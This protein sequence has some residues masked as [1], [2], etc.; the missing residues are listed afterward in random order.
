MTI[1]SAIIYWK[2]VRFFDFLKIV[3]FN[4]SQNILAIK[5]QYRKF[6]IRLIFCIAIVFYK[7]SSPLLFS[8]VCSSLLTIWV[9]VLSNGWMYT[10][11]L[12]FLVECLPF[13]ECKLTLRNTHLQN[14]LSTCRTIKDKTKR[15]GD[16]LSEFNSQIFFGVPAHSRDRNWKGVSNIEKRRNFWTISRLAVMNTHARNVWPCMHQ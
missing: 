6:I 3:V 2:E 12:Y 16:L 7:S 13:F 15:T 1:N 8:D 14:F 11:M 5:C 9:I 10:Q 4:D